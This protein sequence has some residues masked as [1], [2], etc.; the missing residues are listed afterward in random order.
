MFTLYAHFYGGEKVQ[1]KLSP[2]FGLHTKT[3]Y[4]PNYEIYTVENLDNLVKLVI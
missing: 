3:Y 1:V 2:I 4:F